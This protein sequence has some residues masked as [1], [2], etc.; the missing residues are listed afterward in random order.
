MAAILSERFQI[1]IICVGPK[2]SGKT[3]FIK[4][5]VNSFEDSNASSQI[6]NNSSTMNEKA[7]LKICR[8]KD[9]KTLELDIWDTYEDIASLSSLFSRNAKGCFIICDLS[10]PGTFEEIPEWAEKV[11]ATNN[12][13]DFDI[14]IFLIGNKSD[15]LK[16]GEL[17]KAEKVCQTISEENKFEDY[18][19]CSSLDNINIAEAFKKLLKHLEAN[20]MLSESKDNCSLKLSG[21]TKFHKTQVN[22]KCGCKC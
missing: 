15:I 13:I 4:R 12:L 19:T 18:F 3:S 9:G 22:E 10:D 17:K 6:L 11:R 2:K 5:Y 20:N 7:Y 8:T 21:D 16:D 14:P 1:R